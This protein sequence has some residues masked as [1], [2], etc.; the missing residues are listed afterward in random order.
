MHYFTWFA[1]RVKTLQSTALSSMRRV[2]N[3]RF[4]TYSCARPFQDITKSRF[5]EEPTCWTIEVAVV[6]MPPA[7]TLKHSLMT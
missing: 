4:K 6:G 5:P 7:M 1:D 3:A 2:K